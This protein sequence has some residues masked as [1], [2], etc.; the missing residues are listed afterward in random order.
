MRMT[1]VLRPCLVV[2]GC[3]SISRRRFILLQGLTTSTQLGR[4]L[5]TTRL[6][7]LP[8][9]SLIVQIHI[10]RSP[11]GHLN[12]LSGHYDWLLWNFVTKFWENWNSNVKTWWKFS[13]ISLAVLTRTLTAVFQTDIQNCNC[14]NNITL[15]KTRVMDFNETLQNV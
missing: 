9:S 11:V 15:S 5:V 4:P 3:A 6:V 12:P 13:V 1:T 2:C 8:R 10:S 7:C 14:C